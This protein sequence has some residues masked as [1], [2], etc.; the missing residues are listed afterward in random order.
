[1]DADRAGNSFTATDFDPATGLLF[2]RISAN[3]AILS[4]AALFRFSFVAAPALFSLLGRD[5]TDFEG[6]S[7]L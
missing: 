7:W 5:G 1:L 4:A 2:P 3:L 6:K